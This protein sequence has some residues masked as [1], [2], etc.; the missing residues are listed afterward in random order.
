M[1]IYSCN[2]SLYIYTSDSIW[3]CNLLIGIVIGIS[4]L[5]SN[6]YIYNWDCNLLSIIYRYVKGFEMV[7]GYHILHIYIM[8]TIDIWYLII[9]HY[10]NRCIGIVIWTTIGIIGMCNNIYMYRIMG[11]VYRYIYYMCDQIC[12]YFQYCTHRYVER[13][14]YVCDG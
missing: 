3:D 7:P 2:I 10:N 9:Y 12:P 13:C 8:Y 14:I 5:I 6:I 11:F 4:Y 1:L